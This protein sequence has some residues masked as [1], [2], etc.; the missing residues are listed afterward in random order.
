MHKTALPL[1]LLLAYA[2]FTILFSRQAAAD[3]YKTVNTSVLPVANNSKEFNVG[4]LTPVNFEDSI[5]VLYD[6]IGLANHGL[7]YDVFRMGII[8]YHA[9][10]DEGVLNNKSILTI[11]DFSQPSTQKRFYTIDLVNLKLQYHTYVAHGRNTGENLAKQFS[12]KQYSNQSS[13]G[14]YVTGE[15]YI[16]SKGFS[17]KL[18]G[19]EENYNDRIRER[20]VV[21]HDA[22]YVSEQWIKRYGRLGRSQGCPALPKAIS[23]QIINT[24][25]NRTAIFAYYPDET[26]IK[27]SRYLDVNNLMGI[28]AKR[29]QQKT[30]RK[31]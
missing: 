31:I 29:N 17:L 1:I 8:G 23:K 4:I 9:L 15:T 2:F 20:A 5:R 11:I 10:S 14:F 28:L 25:K 7:E 26:Y 22:D 30:E 19:K 21:I 6:Y 13:L 3:H 16:G 24:I 12:N 18:D 27:S